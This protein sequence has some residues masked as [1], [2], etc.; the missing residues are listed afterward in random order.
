M[1]DGIGF[2]GEM[3]FR[4]RNETSWGIIRHCDRAK[5]TI[6]VDFCEMHQASD[7]FYGYL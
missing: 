7:S 2:N 4:L 5:I 3:F 1:E 6:W